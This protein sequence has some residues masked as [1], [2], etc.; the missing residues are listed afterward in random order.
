MIQ[1]HYLMM[2]RINK[3]KYL[4]LRRFVQISI[5]VLFWGANHFGWKIL[6]GNLS[7]AKVLDTFYLADPVFVLEI[8]ATGSIITM[9]IFVGSLIVIV[10]YG[11]LTGRSFCSWVCP[12]NIITD[13][14]A[15]LR[16]RGIGE[17]GSKYLKLSRLVRYY[18]LILALILSFV[19]GVAAYEVLNPIGITI[20][21]VVF[22][23]GI[24]GTVL[25]MIFLFY[26]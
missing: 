6:A 22:G 12:I 14:A 3:Y 18:I 4:I 8:L 26:S 9:D 25:L 5:L 13:S 7:T 20:R 15:W 24:G 2:N 11:L 16:R 1:N 21:G 10:F 19:L 17:K 23:F